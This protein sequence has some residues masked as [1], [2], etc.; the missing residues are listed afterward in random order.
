MLIVTEVAIVHLQ[1]LFR[2]GALESLMS[3]PSQAN[4]VLARSRYEVI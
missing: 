4:G 2:T 1:L 3:G